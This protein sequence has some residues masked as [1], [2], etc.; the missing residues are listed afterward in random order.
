MAVFASVQKEEKSSE[1]ILQEW[2][3]WFSSNLVRSLTCIST[4]TNRYIVL[5]VNIFMLF[6]C[7]G[8]T[9]LLWALIVWQPRPLLWAGIIAFSKFLS[10]NSVCVLIV[11]MAETATYWSHHVFAVRKFLLMHICPIQN[12]ALLLYSCLYHTEIVKYEW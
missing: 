11:S 1:F 10:I 7:V 5:C 9:L 8:C 2:L 3:G 12:T 6:A 4:L